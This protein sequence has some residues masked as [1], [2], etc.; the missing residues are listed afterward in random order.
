MTVEAPVGSY[1][2]QASHGAVADGGHG[3]QVDVDGGGHG[4]LQ[5]GHGKQRLDLMPPTGCKSKPNNH[6]ETSLTH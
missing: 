1:D 2:V 3:G 5:L 6:L 4:Q